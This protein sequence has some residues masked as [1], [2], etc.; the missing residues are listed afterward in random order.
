MENMF[1]VNAVFEGENMH[2]FS[3]SLFILGKRKC[4]ENAQQ[5][6]K[7]LSD[8]LGHENQEVSPRLVGLRLC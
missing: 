4:S 8:L 2:D 1:F 7:V 3:V 5:V 6:L